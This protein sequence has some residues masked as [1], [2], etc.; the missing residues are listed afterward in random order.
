MQSVQKSFPINSI[1][2]TLE[3]L[4]YLTPKSL[5]TGMR[6]CPR[7]E[8][9]HVVTCRYNAALPYYTPDLDENMNMR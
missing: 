9:S 3:F 6:P 8:H 1:S 4:S 7:A 5:L 2:L